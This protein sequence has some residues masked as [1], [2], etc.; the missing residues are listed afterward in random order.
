MRWAFEM[1]TEDHAE[2][3]VVSRELESQLVE[4]CGGEVIV[5]EG[6]P[7]MNSCMSASRLVGGRLGGYSG[8]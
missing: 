1:Y 5:S 6:V 3:L 8:N 7:G 4:L 2:L